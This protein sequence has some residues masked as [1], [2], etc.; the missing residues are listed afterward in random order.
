MSVPERPAAAD[1]VLIGGPR[2]GHHYMVGQWPPP[3]L[4]RTPA[5]NHDPSR[6]APT[7]TV[8]E[9]HLRLDAVGYP[10]RDEAGRIRYDYRPGH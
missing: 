3:P 2:D 6:L 4:I 1:C 9:Y 8:E 10:S 7:I 5:L